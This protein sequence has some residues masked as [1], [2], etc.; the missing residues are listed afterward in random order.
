MTLVFLLMEMAGVAGGSTASVSHLQV[1]SAIVEPGA[2]VVTIELTAT[3]E[4]LG[5]YVIDVQYDSA[6]VTAFECT[7][8]EGPCT[9]DIVAS[10]TVRFVG[11]RV[12]GITGSGVL[13]GMIGFRV[14]NTTGTAALT[15]DETTLTLLDTLG[16]PLVVTPTNGSIMIQFPDGDGDGV[17]DASDNCPDI[18]NP[19]QQNTVHPGTLA[20]DHCEDPDGDGVS[21]FSDTCPNEAGSPTN[22]GCPF[23]PSIGGIVELGVGSSD[24]PVEHQ[25]GAGS[26]L[27]VAA[28]AVALAAVGVSGVAWHRY[29]RRALARR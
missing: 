24:S 19:G 8:V 13:L 2:R 14:G 20:G 3:T 15:I 16:N 4:N 1:G 17:P 5:S 18:A 26:Q 11:S 23:P 25:T 28:L 27:E 10:D 22:S 7:F 9:I 6:L 21:D 12:G 29:R